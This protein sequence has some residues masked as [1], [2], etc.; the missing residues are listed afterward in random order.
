MRTLIKVHIGLIFFLTLMGCNGVPEKAVTANLVGETIFTPLDISPSLSTIY[1]NQTQQFIATGGEPPYT[2]HVLTGPGSIDSEGLFTAASTQ[3]ISTIQVTDSNGESKSATVLVN[4]EMVISPAELK[5][6]ISNQYTFEAIGGTPPYTFNVING[7][8]AIT[9]SGEFTASST[10]ESIKVRVTDSTG[11]YAEADVAVGNGPIISPST[12]NVPVST[13]EQFS[14]SS[15]AAP[16]T[17]S[18]TSGL[19]TVDN[20]GLFNADATNGTVKIKVTDANGFYSESTV[21]VFKPKKIAAGQ[22]HTCILNQETNKVKCLGLRVNGQTGDG[23]FV[24][25]DELTDMGDSLSPV[26]FGSSSNG[27]QPLIFSKGFYHGCA[28]FDDGMTRCWGYSV[29]GQNGTNTVQ[30]STYAG[31]TDASI[32]PVPMDVLSNPIVDLA[33]KGEGLHHNCGIYQNGTLKCWGYNAYGQLGQNNT[34]NYGTDTNT[35]SLYNVAVINLGQTVRKV[36][37]GANHTCAILNDYNVKCW[38]HNAYGQLGMQTTTNKGIAAGDM[39]AL[40]LHNFTQDVVDL[41]LGAQHT[42][43]LLAD[44]NVV[45]WGY[46]ANGEIGQGQV[47]PYGDD[48]GENPTLLTPIPLGTGRTAIKI[49]AGYDHTCVVLDNNQVKCWGYNV[50]GELGLEDNVN[51]G[52][53]G[54]LGDSLAEVNLGAGRTALNVF[55][56]AFGTCVE[57]DTHEIKCWGYN[58]ETSVGIGLNPLLNQGDGPAEMGDNLPAV[59]WGSNI[60]SIISIA[61]G[62][63]S[64]CAHLIDNGQKVIKCIGRNDNGAVGI[65]NFSVGD[66]PSDLGSNVVAVELGTTKTIVDVSAGVHHTCARFQDG[67]A[68]CWGYNSSLVLGTNGGITNYGT[69]GY[70]MGTNLSYMV[71]GSGVSLRKIAASKSLNYHSCALTTNNLLK[72]WGY[73]ANGQLG[74]STTTNLSYIPAIGSISLGAGRYATDFSTGGLHTCAVLDNGTV[75]CW[76]VNTFGGLGLGHTTTKGNLAGDMAALPVVD[77]G[78]GVLASQITSGEYHNCV[79]TTTNKVKCWGYNGNGMLGL[80]HINNMGDNAGEMGNSLPYVNLGTGRTA[81]K[82]ASG[83]HHNCAILDNKKLKCWGY[84]GFGDLGLESINT[85][86]AGPMGDSLPYVNVGTGRTVIDLAIGQ[87]HTCVVLD[88][89]DVKCWG[90]NDQGQLG[91]G[92][93]FRLGDEV[94]EMSSLTPI[95]VD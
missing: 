40:T 6:N 47:T 30:I 69:S 10:A 53:Y 56:G 44:G 71:I 92:H 94:G 42:C 59:N 63:M 19:G 24:I 55:A 74:Q 9:N 86:G 37:T 36:E 41:A 81:I 85:F 8:S 5:I 50:H 43:V 54:V 68:K 2:F 76:G 49:D 46:S 17:W 75:K 45:C 77:L 21:T 4:S 25:G 67:T 31:V 82:I 13:T 88:N 93:L 35:L 26:Y 14:A 87:D 64:T 78:T 12:A 95:Q 33:R 57:L 39:A 18:I 7:T 60:S 34:A 61:V 11:V 23:K 3:G 16:L 62:Q 32:L 72:C 58:T 90:N 28:I 15:G 27:H 89:N 70:N 65:E 84:N 79:I 1:I 48:P 66:E 73:N 52:S 83:R 91:K 51:R 29:H 20:T 22:S 80:G 38:G